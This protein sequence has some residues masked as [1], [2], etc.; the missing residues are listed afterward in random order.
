M[1]GHSLLQGRLASLLAGILSVLKLVVIY[2]LSELMIWGCSRVLS[3]LDAPFF[4]SIV[5]MVLV[6]IGITVAAAFSPLVGQ[7]YDKHLKFEVNLINSHL[8]VGFPIPLIMLDAKSMLAAA[9][10]GRVIGSF[11]RFSSLFAPFEHSD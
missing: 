6:A 5:S 3:I 11:S 2:L 1:A 8:G 4:A 10:I 9:T 7:V